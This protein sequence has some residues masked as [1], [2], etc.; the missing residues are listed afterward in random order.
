M[1]QL[2]TLIPPDMSPAFAIMLIVLSF[3]TSMMTAAV[4]IGGGV[5]LLAVMAT[6]VPMTVLVP[7][8][9]VIQ[10]GSNAGRA[11]VHARHA[12]RSIMFYIAAGGLLGAW[13]G[14]HLAVQLPDALLK[15]GLGAF[16]LWSLWGKKPTYARLPRPLLLLAG[17]V[18]SILTMF[19]GATGPFMGAIL[20]PMMSNRHVFV[21]TFAACMTFQHLIKVVVFG[22]L[23]FA[24][25]PWIVLMISMIGTG[26]LG[27]LTGTMLLGRMPEA[28]FRKVFAVVMTVLAAN[29]LLQGAG[30]E[31]L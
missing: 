3:L 18:T 13:I 27:T 11:I 16:V 14:G 22:L 28:V 6:A 17:F 7:V 31:L 8:H 9:G 21:G 24:F 26:F 4:G 23:G 5:V 29:L 12:D 19:I 15:A 25:G 20:A 30:V 10:F 1:D 2:I